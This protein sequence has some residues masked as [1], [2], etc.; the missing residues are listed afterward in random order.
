[1]R[2]LLELVQLD[3]AMLARRPIEMSGGQRQ[4]IAI[5]RALAPEPEVIVCDEP[6]SALDVSVQA[7]I[8]DLLGDLQ[9]ELG[10][11]YLFIS[12]DLGVIHHLSDRVLVMKDGAVVESGAVEEIF[13]RPE[14][15]YTQTLLSAVPRLTTAGEHRA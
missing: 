3:E 6:V 1:L 11:A 4:R 8:L 9:R 7:R 13:E 15:P 10:L 14:H 12:H 5:A 2:E